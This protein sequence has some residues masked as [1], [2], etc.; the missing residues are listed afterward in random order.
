MNTRITNAQVKYLK[1][2][3]LKKNRLEN[4]QFII[5]G[6]ESI[7]EA[8]NNNVECE[9]FS[10]KEIN[11]KYTFIEQSKIDQILKSKTPPFCFA[12]CNTITPKPINGNTVVLEFI[13]DP[14]NLGTIIRNCVAFGVENLIVEGVD[15]YNDKVLRSSKGSLFKLN[16]IQSDNS[17]KTVEKLLKTHKIIGTLLDKDALSLYDFNIQKHTDKKPWVLVFGNESN[18][19]SN[20]MKKLLEIKLYIQIEFE[21]L[22][23]ANANAIMLYEF[24]KQVENE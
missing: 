14:G 21:S 1:S 8:M 2:L 16:I 9:I 20:D 18:G 12:L 7:D 10:S 6:I 11:Y 24:K 5:E 4:N 22:N 23:I 19:I 15:I 17:I 3:Q 13:Q